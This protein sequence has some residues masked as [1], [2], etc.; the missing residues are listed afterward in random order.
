MLHYSLAPS[1]AYT[2]CPRKNGP[3]KHALKFSKLASFAQFQFN[4]MNIC[5]FSIKVPIL[6]KIYPTI[7]EIWT[8]NKWSQMFTVSRSVISYLQSMGVNW[9]QHRRNSRIGKTKT[10]KMVFSTE[11][12]VL[13][14][15]LHQEK[16]Y[17]NGWIIALLQWDNCELAW[18]RV[19]T[20]TCVLNE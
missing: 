2:L 11:N 17:D 19:V 12:L 5:L 13:I 7:I 1:F 10:N 9:R 6:V 15:V 3:P 4:S 8:L 20:E 18:V 14:K 16:G